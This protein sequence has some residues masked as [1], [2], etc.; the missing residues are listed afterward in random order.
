MIEL[1]LIFLG[2]LLGSA[3]CVGMCG[4]FAVLIGGEARGIGGNLTRQVLYS[5][6]RIFTYS[7]LGGG[8]GYAGLRLAAT[9]PP[10][11][12]AQSMLALLAGALLI[13]AGL[14]AAGVVPRRLPARWLRG[15]NHR[16]SHAPAPA[17]LSAGLLGTFLRAPGWGHVFLA[18]VFTGFLPCG[19]VYGFLALACST[20]S[21]AGGAATMAAFGLGTVP[22]MVLTGAS[23]SLLSIVARRRLLRLAAWC[24]VVV[25]VVSLSRGVAAMSAAD[26]ANGPACPLC[27]ADS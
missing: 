16:A 6:G 14:S 12:R 3:H 7:V 17:C 22:L 23:A 1:P 5:L 4:G 9:L 19:L 11:V 2:G 13:V 20:A 25:G 24:V 15:T 26:D 8:L 21:L 10:V 18:G 27:A